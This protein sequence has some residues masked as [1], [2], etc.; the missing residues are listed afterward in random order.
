MGRD[1]AMPGHVDYVKNYSANLVPVIPYNATLSPRSNLKP[2]HLGKIPGVKR[3]DGW[4][5]MAWRALG[6]VDLK[7]AKLW[8]EMGAGVGW[9]PGFNGVFGIDVDLLLRTAS[10][11]VLALATAHFG[12]V[13]VRRVD[14]PEHTKLL[15][16]ARMIGEMPRS[17]DFR[18]TNGLVQFLGA[19]KYFNVH[20]IHPARRKPYVWENDPAY[21][22]LVL[23]SRQNFDRFWEAV[24]Q[25]FDAERAVRVHSS[26]E[27]T[28]E[29]ETCSPEELQALVD[30][31]PNDEEF[32]SY[33]MFITFGS[34]VYGASK[35]QE[36]G[37]AIFTEWC[38]Q[39]EQGDPEKP[40]RFW[41]TMTKARI[42]AEM[43]RRWANKRNP[44][45]MA[46]RAFADPPI[47]PE[48]IEEADEDAATATAFLTNYG[49]VGGSEFYSLPPRQPYIA[50][51][52]NLI[53]ARDEKSLRRHFGRKR[54]S[55]A[56]IFAS[57]SPNQ[58]EAV[59][60]RPGQPRIV[61]IDG[62]RFLNLWSPPARPWQ[63]RAIDLEIVD[64][65]RDLVAFVLGSDDEAR[66]WFLWHAYLLQ[67][68]DWAPGWQWIIQTDQGLGKDLILRPLGRAHGADYINAAPSMLTSV[69]NSYAEKHL[70][71]V[72]EMREQGRSDAYTTLKTITSGTPE[73]QIH[74]KYKEPYLAPNVAGFVIYSNE[75]N[76]IRIAHDDRRFHVVSNFRQKPQTPEFY[77]RMVKL[78][79]RHWA[80]LA[81]HLIWLRIS[82]AD[83]D[84]LQGNAPASKAKAVMAE[85]AW[86][87]AYI[88]IV[89]DL[90]SAQPPPG[91]FPVTTTTDLIKWFKAAELP[92]R[93]LP[94]RLNFPTDL[95]RLGARPL[96]PAHDNPQRA[97]PVMGVRLWRIART[98]RDQK[99]VEWD[100]EA[101]SPTRL[102]R[103][104]LDRAMPPA[105]L[106]AVD[107]EDV[108]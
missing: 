84:M 54:D 79:D 39:V 19:G 66:L 76:P 95:Y 43:L 69:Y 42:G 15:I 58:F 98:W 48:A 26:R 9:R 90:E 2:E 91:Y 25:E 97:N 6:E 30:E 40:D 94:N 92:P 21:G 82:D 100:I 13:A 77:I 49:L 99:G 35:G 37:R 5:G 56:Q 75:L 57:T 4:T 63:G 41:N 16:C 29:P 80:M 81:E 64:A 11:R 73:I 93:D 45:G 68:P 34:A 3:A 55:L 74:R 27:T 1:D 87:R 32:E 17:F 31:I 18:L 23:V 104:Y 12:K 103:L 102:A 85:E 7:R 47:E 50:Q 86:E 36:W 52:F 105:D 62:A 78:L 33:D 106:S 71:G 24:H 70:I 28:R 22:P 53:H 61:E 44:Q 10:E 108:V 14:H 67:H 72:S 8:D 101:I 38:D 107:D 88:D 46:K 65:Y 60:H 89:G 59:T 20:G 96:N 83:L 51:A